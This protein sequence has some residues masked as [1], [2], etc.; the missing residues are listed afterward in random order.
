VTP[1]ATLGRSSCRNDGARGR[2]LAGRCAAPVVASTI[3]R[4]LDAVPLATRHRNSDG[5]SLRSALIGIKSGD[6]ANFDPDQ[7]IPRRGLEGGAD[8]GRAMVFASR[9]HARMVGR[10]T[11]KAFTSG[12]DIDTHQAERR[13]PVLV[14]VSWFH[15]PMTR[16]RTSSLSAAG[17]SNAGSSP[18]TDLL[19]HRSATRRGQAMRSSRDTWSEPHRNGT[20]RR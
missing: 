13:V 18:P 19:P 20:G 1:P 14:S 7:G 11:R 5:G 4:P 16:T 3:K 9:A 8:L 10:E 17:L 6:Q 2:H 15:R 12:R